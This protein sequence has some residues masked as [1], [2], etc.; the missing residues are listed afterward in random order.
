MTSRLLAAA[1]NSS[2]GY[3]HDRGTGRHVV[4]DDGASTDYRPGTDRQ[5]WEHSCAEPD[6]RN[7]ADGHAS[8][9]GG[10]GA[11][12]NVLTDA[13]IVVDRGIRIDDRALRDGR[14]RVHDGPRE[15]LSTWGDRSGV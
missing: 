15:E 8:P 11:D 13:A 6:E 9:D 5:P 3:A 2:S 14:R 10:A 7:F 12:V 1:V 4:D